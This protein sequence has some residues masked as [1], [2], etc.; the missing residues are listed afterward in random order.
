MEPEKIQL[1]YIDDE[2]N[3]L[4]SATANLRTFCKVFTA[5]SAEEGRKILEKE[6]IHVIVT[7]QRMPHI[8]GVEF[9][10]SIIE[11]HPE[12]IRILL[13]GY[14]DIEA[15]IGAINKGQVYRYLVKPLNVDELKIILVDAYNLYLFR[16]RN[17][18]M[19]DKYKKIFEGSGDAIFVVDDTGKLIDFNQATVDLLKYSR[20]QLQNLTHKDVLE[21]WHELERIMQ[22]L[23]NDR[24]IKNLEIK[25][26]DSAANTL[27]CLLSI[28]P[29]HDNHNVKVGYQ[30]IIKNSAMKKNTNN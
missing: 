2:P 30:G 12:P 28:N 19:V 21:N 11:E 29:I 4:V 1:L 20:S 16:K 22:E 17:V 6:T 7:D 10:E 15:V 24:V 13:T 5:T 3:N 14:S 18:D 23:D 27:D 26:L 8:T 9:L 25:L